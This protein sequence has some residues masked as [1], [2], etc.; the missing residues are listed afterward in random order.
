MAAVRR[1]RP[2]GQAPPRRPRSPRSYLFSQS[3]D[4]G[5]P[6][7]IRQTWPG[8]TLLLSLSPLSS[9]GPQTLAQCFDRSIDRSRE[10]ERKKIDTL[11]ASISQRRHDGPAAERTKEREKERKKEKSKTSESKQQVGRDRRW[12]SATKKSEQTNKQTHTHT[13]RKRARERSEEQ[14][15]LITSPSWSPN[16]PSLLWWWWCSCL[17]ICVLCLFPVLSS[18]SG[19]ALFNT[20]AAAKCAKPASIPA[21]IYMIRRGWGS[22]LSCLVLCCVALGLDARE[23]GPVASEL[24]AQSQ[25]KSFDC[26]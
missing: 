3:V 4:Q 21:N 5:K 20:A 22:L 19:L 12:P 24:G 14:S 18:S 25:Y 1:R 16:A 13:H 15:R 6:S 26:C 8:S 11:C 2:T 17:S 7:H 10:R 23:L 9:L